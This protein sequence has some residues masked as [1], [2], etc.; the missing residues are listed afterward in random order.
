[1]RHILITGTNRGIGLE[2]TRQY[3]QTAETHVIATARD[4]QAEDLQALIAQHPQQITI[5]A[6]DVTQAESIAHAV[7]QVKRVTSKIDIL[8]LNAGVNPDDE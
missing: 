4:P 5:V 1:M 3:A 8:I 7:E 2:L 6:L